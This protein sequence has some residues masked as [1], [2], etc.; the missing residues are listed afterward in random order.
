MFRPIV[1]LTIL[2]LL[3]MDHESAQLTWLLNQ[4]QFMQQPTE[5]YQRLP[6][7]LSPYSCDWEDN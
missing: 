2:F 1:F 4:R 6:L 3:D 5:R 7:F